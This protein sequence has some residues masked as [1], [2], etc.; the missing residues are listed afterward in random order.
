MND[1]II[2]NAVSG[3]TYQVCLLVP[4]IGDG[5]LWARIAKKEFE[6]NCLDSFIIEEGLDGFNLQ[7]KKPDLLFLDLG[8]LALGNMPDVEVY[9][10]LI[11]CANLRDKGEKGVRLAAHFTGVFGQHKELIQLASRLSCRLVMD[12][13]ITSESTIRPDMA[14]CAFEKVMDMIHPR[15]IGF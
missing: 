12:C 7:G 4:K 14:V 10:L 13:T 8:N 5:G 15:N 9:N 2:S 3:L 6:A 1:R 11:S